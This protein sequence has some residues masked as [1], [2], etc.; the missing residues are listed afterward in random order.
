[1]LALV[2][3]GSA[4][5]FSEQG[6]GPS[7][8]PGERVEEGTYR[9]QKGTEFWDELFGVYPVDAG[10]RVVS[11]A[12]QGQNILREADLLYGPDWSPLGGTITVRLPSEYRKIYAVSDPTVLV[13]TQTG[14]RE[15]S[16]SLTVDSPPVYI[17]EPEIVASW[18]AFNRVLPSSGAVGV[19]V[20]PLA[21]E[22]WDFQG[23]GL[24]P[25]E[26]RSQGRSVP[27]EVREVQLGSA[28]VQAYSQGDLVLGLVAEGFVA[29]L[30]EV[31]PP[32]ALPVGVP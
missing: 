28:T 12:H 2:L 20:A 30:A 29:Y 27:A 19:A 16:S 8:P 18:Y 4:L 3:L 25:V 26:L 21:E 22:T 9:V 17:L 31:L 32:G 1:M 14:I 15:T 10:F 23:G 7:L 13:T 24:T 5:I 11:I 6:P